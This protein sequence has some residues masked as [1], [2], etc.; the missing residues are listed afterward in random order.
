MAMVGL[1]GVTAIDTSVAAVTVSVAAGLVTP[2]E[3]AVMAEVPVAIPVARPAVVIV[4]TP[5]VA[6]FHTAVP[7]RFA[8]VP[9]V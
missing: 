8:V 1:V 7:V 9:S 6:E 5:G 3:V 4:A 2:F